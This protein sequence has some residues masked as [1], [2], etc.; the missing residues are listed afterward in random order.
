MYNT[1]SNTYVRKSPESDSV[2]KSLSNIEFGIAAGGGLYQL[3]QDSLMSR[4]KGMK[5]LGVKWVRFDVDWSVIQQYG[6]D[7]YNWA[8]YDRVVSDLNKLG[9]KGL[10]II[11]YTPRWARS[12]NC[13]ESN[14]C[15]PADSAQFAEFA[16]IVAKRYSIQGIHTWEIWNEPN[17]TDFWKPAPDVQSYSNIVKEAYMA[18]KQQDPS[19]FVISGGLSRASTGKGNIS[20]IDFLEKLY[21]N[22]SSKYFDA[23]AF[24]PYSFPVSPY[25]V[26]Q[27]NAWLQIASTS[28][29]LRSV[30]IKNNDGD[31]KIWITEFGAP[32]GGPGGLISS[33]NYNGSKN[34]DHVTES[35]QS[36]IISDAVNLTEKMPW[37]DGPLFF[38]TYQDSGTAQNTIENFFG[39]IRY[40]GTPK[41]AYQKL[42]QLITEQ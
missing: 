31:K 39:L 5:E 21:A 17:I 20:P 30:M 1:N 26:W 8:G 14:K 19:A 6:P 36:Q 9:L 33:N 35:I 25:Y 32:T 2:V 23:V 34:S 13:L 38:Y 4:L 22:G 24:H 12:A 15:A 18:I 41:P 40:D 42:K 16:Q 29:S 7:N 37:I 27:G 11:T 10:G 3:S 28:P